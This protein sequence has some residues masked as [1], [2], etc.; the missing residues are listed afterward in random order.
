MGLILSLLIGLAAGYIAGI[1]MK[2]RGHGLIL[3][4]I[5]GLVGGLLGGFVFGLLG[6][7][8]GGILWQLISAKIGAAILLWFVSLIGGKR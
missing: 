1:L 8:G 6:V 7:A 4:L 2:G 5:I 3:N